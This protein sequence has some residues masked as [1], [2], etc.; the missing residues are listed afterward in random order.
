MVAMKKTDSEIQKDVLGEL[1]WDTRV[2][3]TDV[4]VAV[5]RG[6]VTLS[7]NVDSWAKREAAQEAAH[8]VAGVLDVANDLEVQ[9]PASG[10]RSDTD[11]ARAVRDSLEW[12]VLVPDSRIRSTVY[13]GEVTLEG[14]VDF[15][16][17]RGDA[18]RAVRNL[19]G[20]TRVIN[21]LEV[22]PTREAARAT[23]RA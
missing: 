1:E 15:D 9:L 23:T 5:D 11:I 20:V 7:G 21:R 22:V 12:D 19:L 18:A 3:A 4:G 13:K 10:R 8:R 17:Q 6:V 16:T 2:R 14:D